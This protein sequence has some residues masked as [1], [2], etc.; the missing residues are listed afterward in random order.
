MSVTNIAKALKDRGLVEQ[1][2]GDMNAF[3]AEK[4][5]VYLGIDPTADS[6]HVGN[7]VPIF[8][9]KH[10]ADAGHDVV[11]IVGG[12]TGMIGDP[13]ES[14]ERVLL[15]AETVERNTAA[16]RAQLGK[17]FGGKQYPIFNN[18]EWL[19]KLGIIE[20]LR[21][22][23]KHF[24]VNQL[25]KRE[26]IKK[27]LDAEDPLSFTEFSYS[28]L[29]GYDYLHLFKTEG[30]DLQVGGSDQW[31]NILSG[32]ELIRRKEGAAAYALTAPMI[33]DKKS[34]KKFGK[35]EG[36]AVWIDPEK[37]SPFAFYQFWVNVSDEGVE[38]YLKIFTFLPLER[39]AE[40]VAEHSAD[41]A[42]R[43][44]Q[45]LL[46]F[47]ATKL[48]HGEEAARNAKRVSDLVFG[49]ALS[50]SSLSQPEID[51][52]LRSMPSA[53]V[54]EGSS[55]VDAL[56]AA[57]L[58]PSKS[59]ARRLIEGRGVYMNN[60]LIETPDQTFSA[61]GVELL[62]VGRKVALLSLK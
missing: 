55:V 38:D 30:V 47:E 37:T 29:Q 11:F 18:A 45:E 8:L 19:T 48:V 36:N 24:T 50:L 15:D 52:L 17:I 56:V 54:A 43:I 9:M 20:F 27:R 46:A 59:E 26:I 23:A 34:G 3:L 31:T 39:I 58:A 12:G 53:V 14:G 62:R 28:L 61:K 60:R 42:K 16:I 4:R 33:I 51:S 7:L 13:R 1:E 22:I 25:I 49:D 10:L 6:F 32:V 2:A 57:G 21:D 41:P 44:A 5:K 35:S 40:I